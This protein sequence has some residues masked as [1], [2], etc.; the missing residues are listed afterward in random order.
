MVALLDA[1]LGAASGP[2]LACPLPPPP[3]PLALVAASCAPTPP[4]RKP[5]ITV[6][7]IAMLATSIE[8]LTMAWASGRSLILL[9]KAR[10]ITHRVICQPVGGGGD[11]WVVRKGCVKIGGNIGLKL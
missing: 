1:P 5:W 2:V 9:M 6:Y 3:P 4:L 10:E 7:M 11:Q 8:E